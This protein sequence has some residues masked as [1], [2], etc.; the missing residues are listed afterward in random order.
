MSMKLTY[1]ATLEQTDADFNPD[2]MSFTF[3]GA[4]VTAAVS[5]AAVDLQALATAMAADLSA[6][7][8]A[9]YPAQVAQDSGNAAAGGAG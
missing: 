5:P 6:Q 8:V 3:S 2:G 7:M 4:Q 9:K 1:T